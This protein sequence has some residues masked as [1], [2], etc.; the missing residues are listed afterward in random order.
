MSPDAAGYEHFMRLAIEEAARAGAEGNLA[1]GAVIVRDDRVVVTGRNLEVTT[2]DPTAHAEMVAIREGARTVGRPAL[3]GLTLYTTW[4]PCPM[5]TGAAMTSGIGRVVMGARYDPAVSR[6]RDYRVEGLIEV[7]RWGDRL[8]L[9]TGV[10]P[11]E[12]Q[13]VRLQWEARNAKK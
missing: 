9:V 11:E 5:C 2:G 13:A 4:E 1:V 3:A 8:T 6:W 10:L 7:T 12:C